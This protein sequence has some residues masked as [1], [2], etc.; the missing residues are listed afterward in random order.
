MLT[1]LVAQGLTLA[2]L[3]RF[4]GVGSTADTASEI[5]EL[6]HRVAEAA[7]R[8]VRD[9]AKGPQVRGTGRT[10]GADPV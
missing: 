10:G 1:T 2:P 9:L 8:A 3:V 4:L 6:R 5:A 7:L